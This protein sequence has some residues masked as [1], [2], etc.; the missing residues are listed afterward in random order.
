MSSPIQQ[1]NPTSIQAIANKNPLEL[2]DE[3]IDLIVAYERNARLNWK[4]EEKK[5]SKIDAAPTLKLEDL[6]L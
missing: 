5:K 4:P 3:E 6:G 1:I 2:S